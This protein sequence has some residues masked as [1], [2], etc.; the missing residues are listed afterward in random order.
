[1]VGDDAF[2][3][4]LA[5][6]WQ[7]ERRCAAER[8]IAARRESTL[9]ERVARGDALKSVEVDDLGPAPGDR[10]RLW[11]PFDQP[12]VRLRAGTPVRLWWTDPD[13][14]EAVRA[15]VERRTRDR[16]SVL[17]DGEVADRLLD[18]RFHVDRDDP[19]VTFTIGDRAIKA[20]QAARPGHPRARLGAALWGDDGPVFTAPARWRPTDAALNPSQIEA[21]DVALGASPV[22]LIHGPPGT[23]KT[24]TLVEVI[25]QAVAHGDR[26]LACAMSNTAVDHL[27]VG[28]VRAGIDLVRIGHPS[29]VAPEVATRSL[30]ALIDA[31]DA[32]RLSQGWLK[33]ARRLRQTA[34]SARRRM[35]GAERH[36][37]WVEARRLEQD[38]RLHLSRA[39]EALLDQAPVIC[40]TA[41]GADARVLGGRR[42]DLVVL[43]EATQAPDPLALAAFARAPRIVLAGDPEQLPPTVLDWQAERDGLG[44]TFFERIATRHPV[45][46]RMLTVQ[47]RMHAALMRFPARTRYHDRLTAAPSVAGHTLADLDVAPDGVRDAPLVLIDTA[48]KG[49]DD[50]VDP[51]GSAF[52]PDQAVRTAA[53][54]RRMI[55]RGLG[56]GDLAII[57]P[58]NAHVRLL[59]ELLAAEREAG[60]E[61]GTV[62]GFQG[63]EKEAIIVDLVRSNPDGQVGFVADRRRLNVAFTRARRCMIVIADT[64]TLGQHADFA[65]FLEAVE[66]EGVWVSAWTDDAEPL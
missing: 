49:W 26:V 27:A 52:N 46:C 57:S 10:T 32:H 41:A 18:G 6:L 61:I 45:A 19:Q 63:R 3:D 60:L 50:A 12:D 24:R 28:L 23:G 36:G 59:R 29:R 15:V 38:A 62:D 51:D 47:Y 43:D 31:S 2:L 58:Y 25:A 4:H 7:A 64:A 9:A 48:G 35:T 42:F 1:M 53:E 22:A 21:I 55:S 13:D 40:A 14:T 34:R 17:V 8:A 33:E 5:R 56:P 66:A 30:D 54:A 37:L 20:F 65:A 44:S 39:Q 16:L 11:I